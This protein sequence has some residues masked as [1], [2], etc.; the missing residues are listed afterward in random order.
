[1]LLQKT[2]R[3]RWTWT[4]FRRKQAETV[5]QTVN[6]LRDYWPLTIPSPDPFVGKGTDKH[7]ERCEGSFHGHN[8]YRCPDAGG[9]LA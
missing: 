8:P 2:A 4:E 1:M 7:L 9:P 5:I 6:A 3:R